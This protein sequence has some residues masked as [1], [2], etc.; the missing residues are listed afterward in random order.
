MADLDIRVYKKPPDNTISVCVL[1]SGSKGNS[2]YISDGTTSFLIDAG[3]SGLEIERRLESRNIDPANLNAILVTHEHSDHIQGV[4]VLSRRFKIP[5]YINRKTI[6]AS[7]RIGNLNETRLFE[8]GTPFILDDFSIHPFS[9]SHDARDPAG[10]TIGQNGKRIGIATDLGTVTSMVRENLKQCAL[11]ILEANHDPE[12]L[13]TGPYPWHL[14]QRIKGR[15][16]HLS[17][18][19]SKVLLQELQHESLQKVIL[20]HLSE[21]NNTSQKAF[22]EVSCALTNCDANITVAEQSESSEIFYLR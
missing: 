4:G 11:L 19:E 18:L 16:G 3:L 6:K 22:A 9:I 7:P 14:K 8:C 5:V 1:A 21:T 20:A 13:A 2:T 10:F 15:T 17:N 12:M